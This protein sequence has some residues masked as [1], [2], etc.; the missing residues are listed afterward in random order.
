MSATALVNFTTPDTNTYLYCGCYDNNYNLYSSNY[1]V[2][3]N[4]ERSSG[5][6]LAV[7][8]GYVIIMILGDYKQTPPTFQALQLVKVP[9][10]STLAST[11]GNIPIQVVP[12]DLTNNTTSVVTLPVAGST[13]VL[14]LGIMKDVTK[15]VNSITYDS[16]SD[17]TVSTAATTCINSGNTI[18]GD[19]AV[20]IYPRTD[21]A[22]Y[23]K[24]NIC[25]DAS[26]IK[27]YK[28]AYKTM[29]TLLIIIMVVL[30]IL[31]VV[32]ITIIGFKLRDKYLSHKRN[33]I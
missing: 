22:Y 18:L 30:F 32:V 23:A 8:T 13:N 20:T 28:T 15:M 19:A 29:S 9:D 21:G 14:S 17:V 31:L 1:F 11:S 33:N 16:S 5:S 3:D 7:Q 10:I 12:V 4:S 25:V 6:N 2:Y 27:G 26:V 24:H